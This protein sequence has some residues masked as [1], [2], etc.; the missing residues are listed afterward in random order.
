MNSRTTG[1][2][3]SPQKLQGAASGKPVD[4][5][6][7]VLRPI[8]CDFD[9]GRIARRSPL[10][11]D[12]LGPR[13]V[14]RL[15]PWVMRNSYGSRGLDAVTGMFRPVNTCA[16]QTRTRFEPTWAVR[17][18]NPCRVTLPP[19]PR[20]RPRRAHIQPAGLAG[21]SKPNFV[22]FKY[23]LGMDYVTTR[24]YGE[25]TFVIWFVRTVRALIRTI[26]AFV[27]PRNY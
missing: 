23:L 18:L 6:A 17:K 2:V 27:R 16:Y 21:I 8:L 22:S 1:T 25:T 11:I 10:A 13:D 3:N 9:C 5:R 4:P 15:T 19:D 7:A 12:R 20:Y 24:V 26:N 14:R